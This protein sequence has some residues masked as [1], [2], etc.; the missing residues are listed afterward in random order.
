MASTE[1]VEVKVVDG[2]A[3]VGAG[4]E[5]DPV[6]AGELA[7]GEGGGLGEQV[8]EDLVRSFADVREVLLGDEEKVGWG[9]RIDVGEGD[10]VVVFVDGLDGEGMAGDLAEEAVRHEGMVAESR[11]VLVWTDRTVA[12]GSVPP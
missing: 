11:G 8:A 2:L 1:D 10:G 12:S 9:L 7:F 5:D 6:T 4:V 3:T